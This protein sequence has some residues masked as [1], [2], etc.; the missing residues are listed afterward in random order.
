MV[1]L[2]DLTVRGETSDNT[3]PNTETRSTWSTV[4]Y[5]V[6]NYKCS[7]SK[8]NK[9]VDCK[10]NEWDF[11][12]PVYTYWLNWTRRTSW[13][14]EMNDRVLAVWGRAEGGGANIFVSLK[15]E[16]QSK[17]VARDVGLS[18]QVLTTAPGSHPI[19]SEGLKND[20]F[21]VFLTL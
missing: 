18:K 16:C 1:T 13:G 21:Y 2:C 14:S 8:W 9:W 4:Y 6:S 19:G 5:I 15:L 7:I 12:P 10:W 3:D 20:V 17:G 11:V